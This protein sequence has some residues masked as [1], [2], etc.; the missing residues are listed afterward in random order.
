MNSAKKLLQFD[1]FDADALAR[2]AP[3]PITIFPKRLA[4]LEKIAKDHDGK[5]SGPPD[6]ESLHQIYRIFIEASQK[7]TL[8]T[9]FDSP[10][11]IRQL[12]WALTYSKGGLPRIVDT[13]ELRDALQLIENRFRVSTLPGV[14]NALLEAWNSPNAK[15]LRAFVKKHLTNY[16]GSRK[17]VQKLKE[18]MAWYCE[19]NSATQLAMTLLRSRMKLSDVWSFLELPDHTHSYR[20]FGA[21]AEAYVAR[22]SDLNREA[23][24]NV[25][26]F[27][28]KHKDYKTIRA[29]LSKLIEKLG[30]NASEDLRQPIQSYVL[31]E[32]G[33]PRITGGAVHWHGASDEARQ[34]FIRWITKEDLRFFFDVVAK[35]CN[36]QKFAYRKAF[37]LAYLEHISFCRPVLR[38]DAEYLFSNDPQTL[39]YYRER[40]PA[41]LTGGDSSQHAF[42]IQI[43]NDTFVEFST[44]GAC[45]VYDDINRPFSLDDSK[46]SMFELRWRGREKHWQP[47]PGSERYLWQRNFASWLKSNLGIEPVRS[48]RLDE[49]NFS[50]RRINCP[51]ESCKQTLRIHATKGR[52]RITCPKCKTTFEHEIR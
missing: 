2:R 48:Y 33:D 50:E 6:Q 35:A 13:P 21:V 45:Y 4:I 38:R 52:L 18:N 30:I 20:Y 27:F 3:K 36:D 47:H 26:E 37:W 23:V 34:I 9:E 15:R 11:R 44:A 8:H 1:D 46:Y 12:T 25:V 40:R 22:N 14:F 7:G 10:R 51:N 31:R 5:G 28:E 16:N 43:G 19:E 49:G 29:V 17:F 24:A 32:W 42:I 39:Q 41:T